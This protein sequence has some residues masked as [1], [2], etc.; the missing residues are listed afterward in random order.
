[1]EIT[2]LISGPLHENILHTIRKNQHKIPLVVS[3]WPPKD[4][5]ERKILEDI[6]L[7]KVLVTMCNYEDVP[8]SVDNRRNLAYHVYCWE[9]RITS[10][11]HELLY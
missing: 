5:N 4:E 1:M 3:T 6:S 11:N 8:T 10:S 9:K 7:T 2:L